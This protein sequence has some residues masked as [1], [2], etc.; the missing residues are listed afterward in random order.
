VEVLAEPEPYR[1]RPNVK[2]K[3]ALLKEF[4]RRKGDPNI[5]GSTR[6]KLMT[7]YKQDALRCLA[8]L[9]ENG[10]SKVADIRKSTAVERAAAILRDDYYGWF[11]KTSRG[12]YAPTDQGLN[13]GKEFAEH[14]LGLANKS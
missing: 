6:T 7:A 9:T 13:A 1:P 3:A 5:G 2:R 11:T 10:A 4:K 14:I 8:H 12:I